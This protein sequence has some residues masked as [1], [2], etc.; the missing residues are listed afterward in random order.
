MTRPLPALDAA[1][2]G[3]TD[4]GDMNKS[5]KL[6]PLSWMERRFFLADGDVEIGR[7]EFEHAV[8]TRARGAAGGRSE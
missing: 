5:L 8:G 4:I 2:R 1:Q 6:V 7:L 3:P